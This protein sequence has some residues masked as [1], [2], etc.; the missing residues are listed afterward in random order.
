MRWPMLLLVAATACVAPNDGD[1]IA[2]IDDGEELT[3]V[4]DSGEEEVAE[5]DGTEAPDEL[6][7]PTLAG[8]STV[9][10]EEEA[11]A[12]LASTPQVVYVNFRG[13]TIKNCSDF[14]SDA[15][16]NRSFVMGHFGKASMDFAPFTDTARRAAVVRKL[17]TLFSRWRVTF[18]TKRPAS[19]PYTMLVISPSSLPHHGVAPLDCGNKNPN[20][21]GFVYKIGSSSADLIARFAAHELGHSF[22]LSHVVGSGEVMQWASSGRSFG[23]STYDASHPSGK[24]FSGSIQRAAAMLNANVGAR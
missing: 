14:C 2:P 21:I 11:A 9:S 20:D 17:R 19:P 15:S 18:T 22:G 13:P 6:D 7:L 16:T 10:E 1:V 23:R 5:S 24:C 8:E 12:P 4:D 3:A